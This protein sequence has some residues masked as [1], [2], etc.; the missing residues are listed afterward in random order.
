MIV[1]SLKVLTL[2]SASTS[3]R[4]PNTL[5]LTFRPLSRI[6]YVLTTPILAPISPK[7]K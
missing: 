1:V 5:L 3:K 6:R 2:S 4:M 7:P